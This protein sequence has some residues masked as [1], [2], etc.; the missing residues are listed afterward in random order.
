MLLQDELIEIKWYPANKQRYKE[1]GYV[2]TK[3]KDSFFVKVKDVVEC[4]DGA[5]IP[6]RCDYCGE[7][8]YPTS[9]TYLINHNKGKEDC[10][11]A[12]KGKKISISVFKAGEIPPFLFSKKYQS[13]R[14]DISIHN[15]F[16]LLRYYNIFRL[17]VIMCSNVNSIRD[18]RNI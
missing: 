8:Y 12:C 10:C 14:I 4:S 6:V 9:R 16:F 7:I 17:I 3:M 18:T 1:K 15:L 13:E 11:V 2:F 5:K